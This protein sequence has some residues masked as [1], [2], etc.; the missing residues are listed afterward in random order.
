MVSLF[1]PPL[2]PGGTPP[3]GEVLPVSLLVSSARLLLEQ[4]L[5]NNWVSGEI[6]NFTRASSG[7]C[8]FLLKDERAQVRCVLF[9]HRA[10]GLAF[11]LQDGQ[12]IEVKAVATI[13]EARGEFQLT[14]EALRLAGVGSL[15]EAFAR[16]KARLEA[17]GWFAPEGKRPLPPYPRAI[18]VVTSPAAA[19]LRDVLTTL[20]RRYPAAEVIVYP[21]A[22]QGAGAAEA[23]AAA[24]DVANARAECEVLI[25]T[26][27]GG[28]IED[29]WAFNEEPV[30]A[31]I[32][33]SLLPVVS[34]VGHETDFTIADF[35]ADLRAPT[36][37]A[38]A[39]MVTPDG[40]ALHQ[41]AR[42]LAARLARAAARGLETRMLALDH[43]A[44]RLRHPAA[45][46]AAQSE[47]LRGTSERLARAWAGQNERRQWA[48]AEL[49]ARLKRLLKTPLGHP[50]RLFDLA[51][52]L[53]LA[54]AQQV[55][56]ARQRVD[57][58]A[59]SLALLNP[60]QVLDRGYAI[61]TQP[62]GEVLRDAKQASIGDALDLR[63]ARGGLVARVLSKNPADR[64]TP[65]E[66]LCPKP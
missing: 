26:R 1:S 19:A 31:A 17:Q 15:Y 18:G 3:R 37:T 65:Q 28:S 4:H 7:H 9:R 6:S 50:Q 35:V 47:R 20:R 62:G 51:R 25:L 48:C 41:R 59:R 11:K 43:L 64:Q 16:L 13:Y 21:T 57:Q 60:Q 24:L 42:V 36:P 14:I 40:A 30:A 38:A 22:V 34:G 55:E 44:R 46:L 63:L 10:Q 2:D 33:R 12:H 32:H 49:A 29:L 39:M 61:V 54:G 56:G 58:A 5:P 23:I 66:P 53:P 52:R 8:Y 27:G 45:A